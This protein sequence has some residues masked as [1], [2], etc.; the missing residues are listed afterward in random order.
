MGS[1]NPVIVTE[2]A[3]L[4]KAVEGVFNP[5]LAFSGLKNAALH[6]GVCPPVR[7]CCLVNDLLQAQKLSLA[8]QKDSFIG[9]LIDEGCRDVQG[10]R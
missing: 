4:E 5:L 3:D 8:I 2:N 9:L 10:I 6:P 7:C 1:K